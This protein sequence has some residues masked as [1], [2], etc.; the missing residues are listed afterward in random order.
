MY[1]ALARLLKYTNQ[2]S[3]AL[4][5]A[6]RATDLARALGDTHMLAIAEERCA[7]GLE[8][9][10]RIGEARAVLQDAVPHAEAANELQCL[11]K[12]FNSLA[13]LYL[14]QG[15]FQTSMHYINRALALAERIGDARNVVFD[16]MH[17]GYILFC[18]GE[19]GQA[20]TEAERAAS[21]CHQIGT[22]YVSGH[23]FMVLGF[24][25]YAEG[26]WAEAVTHLEHSVAVAD[27]RA[28]EALV[29]AQSVL[30]EIDLLEGRPAAARSRVVT[31][32]ERCGPQNCD[33]AYLL[34]KL[35]W[36][37]LELGELA[38]AEAVAA[39]A[40]RF[41]QEIED[42]I[43]LVE[44]VRVQA[45]VLMAQH[46]WAEAEMALAGVLPETKRRCYPWGEARVLDT[47]RLLDTRAGA[48]GPAR[49][50]M[51]AALALYK[52]LGARK[53]VE[54]IEQELA[55]LGSPQIQPA[56]NVEN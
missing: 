11:A 37:H 31:L 33:N 45:L 47:Y 27:A 18:S 51:E 39:Q 20:R 21:L 6:E 7:D 32:L 19:W 44:A 53:D 3:A 4:L 16:L 40:V 22:F 24:V 55:S 5:A 14:H 50:R 42:F 15:E 38:Q 36:A 34:P 9:L 41:A 28:P 25:C 30:A 35:A 54:R 52:R 26:Y 8:G 13:H 1:V 43:N 10:G 2:L 17:R 46:R 29:M 48:V 56:T 12:I 23:P 49:E